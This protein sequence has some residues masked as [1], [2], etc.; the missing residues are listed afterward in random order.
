[1]GASDIVTV[2]GGEDA[3]LRRVEALE[4][5]Q[6]ELIPSVGRTVNQMFEERTEN[7][8]GGFSILLGFSPPFPSTTPSWTPDASDLPENAT[9]ISV[10][11]ELEWSH[12]LAVTGSGTFTAAVVCTRI[13]PSTHGGTIS[14]A[15]TGTVTAGKICPLRFPFTFRA[16]NPTEY[17]KHAYSLSLSFSGATF[18]GSDSDSAYASATVT[19]GLL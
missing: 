1:M 18:N 9:N 10:A 8:L 11:G 7:T 14:Q 3:L 17:A 19:Y 2:P 5:W 16:S 4:S 15:Y 6:R 12:G 13:L